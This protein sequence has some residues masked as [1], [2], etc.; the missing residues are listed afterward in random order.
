MKITVY[1]IN[2]NKKRGEHMIKKF[3]T[4]VILSLSLCGNVFA[5]EVTVTGLGADKDSALRDATRLAV[6]QVVGTFIDSR[7]LMKDLLIQVDE[8]Y[9]KSQGFV[10]RIQILEE[11]RA[12]NSTYR[13]VARIDVDTDPNSKLVDEI[14]MLMRLNDPR[15]AVV[16]FDDEQSRNEDA[17]SILIE[18]LLNMNFSHILHSEQVIRQNDTEL[19]NSIISGETGLFQG[20]KD[21]ATDYLVVGKCRRNSKP[22]TATDYNTGEVTD[23]QLNICRSSFKIDVLKYD[24]G[25][26]IGSFTAEGKGFGNDDISARRSADNAALKVAAEKL[27]D[28]FKKF[29]AKTTN[30]LTFTI[31]T[32]SAAN[33]DQILNT[34]RAIGTIDNVQLR[35]QEGNRFVLSIETASRPYEVVDM[36]KSRTKLGVFVENIS[37]SGCRLR[38]T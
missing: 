34:L 30:G 1:K 31:I 24:T 10:K 21:N 27:G 12:D 8:V 28:T 29:S 5:Q 25:E 14:T 13:V 37:A 26:F 15:I 6:E 38:I 19:L 7:T 33:F 18:K 22:V 35:E 23:S 20:K 11:S 32:D 4:G 9:K 3:L 17:E 16:V 2:Q 36:L